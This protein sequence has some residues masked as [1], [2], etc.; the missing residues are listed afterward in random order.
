M[1]SRRHDVR[2]VSFLRGHQETHFKMGAL[3]GGEG[4]QFIAG[5]RKIYRYAGA[6]VCP[7]L[8]SVRTLGGHWFPD[9]C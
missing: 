6:V 3:Q 7:G 9:R 1:L 4:K 5:C 8:Y 2:D